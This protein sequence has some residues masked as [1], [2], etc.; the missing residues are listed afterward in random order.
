MVRNNILASR[1]IHTRA[2]PNLDLP[3]IFDNPKSILKGAPTLKRSTISSHIYRANSAPEDLAALSH[4]HL[5]LDLPNSLPR[6]RSFSIL[7]QPDLELPDPPHQSGRHLGNIHTPPSTPPD[8]HFIQNLG[9]GHPISAHQFSAGHNI[10]IIHIRSA[11]VN[12]LPHQNIVMAAWYA[13]L[14]LPQPL[15]PLPN[16]Y[17]S[18]IPH[19]TAKESITAKHHVDK[20]E[21][22]FNYM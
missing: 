16:D 6:T 5:D 13:P 20:M 12:P 9:L 8:I 3:E 21:Y 10:P 17:Q 2:Y 4:F 19:F 1:T 14:V 11:Q 18:K 22:S 7:D 15:V